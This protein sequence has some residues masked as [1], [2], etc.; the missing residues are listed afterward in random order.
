MIKDKF[1][2]FLTHI[3]KIILPT[4]KDLL[5]FDG[6]KASGLSLDS[7]CL[8][9][10][11]ENIMDSLRLARVVMGDDRLC[12]RSSNTGQMSISISPIENVSGSLNYRYSDKDYALLE[13][14][15]PMG[16]ALIEV[17]G[18]ETERLREMSISSYEYS[19]AQEIADRER[20]S[21]NAKS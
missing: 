4:K 7:D 13:E 15:S 20:R 14:M 1:T 10:I 17:L 9:S 5:S 11:P 16:M 19:I 6:T 18:I 2:V 3:N 21:L 8:A 12:V